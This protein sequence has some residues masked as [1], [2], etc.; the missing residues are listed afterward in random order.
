MET[1]VNALLYLDMFIVFLLLVIGP[2]EAG[3]WLFWLACAM[4]TLAKPSPIAYVIVH[5]LLVGLICAANYVF[6]SAFRKAS[7]QLNI[8]DH[9]SSDKESGSGIAI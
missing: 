8:A 5:F 6:A 3:F 4:Y 9:S 2:F 7:K 1:L